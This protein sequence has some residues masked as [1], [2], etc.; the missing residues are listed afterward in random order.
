MSQPAYLGQ[1]DGYVPLKSFVWRIFIIEIQASSNYSE[2]RLMKLAR[3]GESVRTHTGS[4]AWCPLHQVNSTHK[5]W[6]QIT[7]G[8]DT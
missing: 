8:K 6:I 7:F 3:F 2:V 4:G 5:E 1:S